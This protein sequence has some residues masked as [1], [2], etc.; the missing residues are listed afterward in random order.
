MHFQVFF[1][2][3]NPE[4]LIH[5]GSSIWNI[6]YLMSKCPYLI[7]ILSTKFKLKMCHKRFPNS[8]G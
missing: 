7:H 5:V 6:S 3:E 4:S 8:Q 2:N 1:E